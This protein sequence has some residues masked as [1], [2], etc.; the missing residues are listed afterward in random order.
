MELTL[1]VS[2]VASPRPCFF[3]ISASGVILAGIRCRGDLTHRASNPGGLL[4]CAAGSLLARP[5][6]SAT[7]L[8][9]RRIRPAPAFYPRTVRRDAT[10]P[11]RRAFA[12]RWP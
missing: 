11:P 1:D 10:V 3:F 5:R 4:H 8:R 12:R 7:P 2:S 6:V 9:L